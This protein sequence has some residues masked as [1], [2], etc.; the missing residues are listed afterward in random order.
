[1]DDKTPV[2][3]FQISYIHEQ[4]FQL[5]NINLKYIPEL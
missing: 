2:R 4:K 3:V 1:M 5:R